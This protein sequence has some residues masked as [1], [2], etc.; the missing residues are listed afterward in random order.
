MPIII[1]GPARIN[2]AA[3]TVA[4]GGNLSSSAVAKVAA[5]AA[6]A[7]SVGALQGLVGSFIAIALESQAAKD[8]NNTIRAYISKM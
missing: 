5:T 1:K 2:I 8:A 7:G 4:A 3:N 6:A